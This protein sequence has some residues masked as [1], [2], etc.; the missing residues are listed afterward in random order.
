MPRVEF[1]DVKIPIIAQ[2]RKILQ[3]VTKTGQKNYFSFCTKICALNIVN[4][5]FSIKT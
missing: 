1:H 3:N 4:N 5:D 2:R